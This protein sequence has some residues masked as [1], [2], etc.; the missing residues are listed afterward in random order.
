MLK[1][2]TVAPTTKSKAKKPKTFMLSSTAEGFTNRIT[3]SGIL[4]TFFEEEE[5][6]KEKGLV[7]GGWWNQS[8]SQNAESN[9]LLLNIFVKLLLCDE[10]CNSTATFSV[11]IKGWSLMNLSPLLTSPT[12]AIKSQQAQH[13]MKTKLLCCPLSFK[14][15]IITLHTSLS[16][17]FTLPNPLFIFR[18][19]NFFFYMHASMSVS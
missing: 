8:P 18:K 19:Q 2:I 12:T 10:T 11:C 5:E 9:I 1:N 4:T 15:H 7:S 3:W 13:W 14:L 16:I 6:G 17:L